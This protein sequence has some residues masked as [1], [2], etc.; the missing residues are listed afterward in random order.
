MY[1]MKCVLL[2]SNCIKNSKSAHWWS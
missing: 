2:R 1:V